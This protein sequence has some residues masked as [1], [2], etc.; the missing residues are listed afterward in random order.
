MKT[1]WFHPATFD[2]SEN[3]SNNK[4]VFWFSGHSESTYE[5]LYNLLSKNSVEKKWI[6]AIK[7]DK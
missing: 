6:L 2:K 3:N 7:D 5:W 1:N 4:I